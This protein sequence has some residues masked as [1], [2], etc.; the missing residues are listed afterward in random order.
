[1]SK[2]G[3]VSI[4]NEIICCTCREPIDPGSSYCKKCAENFPALNEKEVLEYAKQLE[5]DR[6]FR[7]G[8]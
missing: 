3:Y 7:F 8:E 1:M 6:K 2:N 4:G 5:D